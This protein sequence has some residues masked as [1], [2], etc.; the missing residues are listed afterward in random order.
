LQD[1]SSS[2]AG[3][4]VLVTIAD[5]VAEVALNR[6]D[7]LNALD[8]PMFEAIIAAGE[9]LSHT[10]DLRAIVM[11][12]AG[13]GFC[14]GLDKETFAATAAGR[15]APGPEELMPRTHGLANS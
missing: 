1:R 2:P 6:P 12:G 15:R 11:T 4:R 5:G 7:K 9:R 8:P 10:P 13:R 14:A 3:D